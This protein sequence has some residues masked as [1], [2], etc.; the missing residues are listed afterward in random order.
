MKNNTHASGMGSFLDETSDPPEKVQ[1]KHDEISW[2]Y[3]SGHCFAIP[4]L[5]P[6]V[7]RH[8][9]T[10][11]KMNALGG[12]FAWTLNHEVVFSAAL[13]GRSKRKLFFPQY[14][15]N[16]CVVGTT[17][18]YALASSKQEWELALLKRRSV[19]SAVV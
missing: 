6:G 7:D 10:R 8:H 3:Y 16:R 2:E 15:W 13:T 19:W 18:D 5:T 1:L 14:C 11:V 4:E 17:D 12:E 9:G